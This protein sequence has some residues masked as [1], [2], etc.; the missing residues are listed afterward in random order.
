M[1]NHVPTSVTGILRGT[2]ITLEKSV[3]PLDGHRV[4]VII[5]LADEEVDLSPAE[6]A[7]L[8]REWAAHGPQGPIEGGDDF[9]DDE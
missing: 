5:E 4:R 6:N 8:L 3:P 1:A 9:P 7:A 2:T